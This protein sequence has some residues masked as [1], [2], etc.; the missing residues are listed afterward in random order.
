MWI[1]YAW[2]VV[3][4]ILAPIV[5]RMIAI[6]S[7]AERMATGPADAADRSVVH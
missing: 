3:S 5:G 6:G 7:A 1:I 2:L 4:V